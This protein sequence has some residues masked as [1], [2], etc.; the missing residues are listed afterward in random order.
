ML[1]FKVLKT[2]VIFKFIANL[3]NFC[4]WGS[5]LDYNKEKRVSGQ[6]GDV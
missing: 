3:Y 5:K 1:V 6:R 4:L 2:W